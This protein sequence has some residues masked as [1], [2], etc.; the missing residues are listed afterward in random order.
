MAWKK[1][2]LDAVRRFDELAG[3]PGAQRKVM[4]GCPVYLLGG[5]RYALLHENRVV[6]RLSAEHAAKL[7]AKGGRP[8]EPMK[9]RPRKDRVV[10]PEAIAESPRSLRVWV[11]RAVEHAQE[12]GGR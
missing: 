8:F 10:V 1:N 7:M 9:G 5:Q 3:V 12:G 4:F 2:S 6:L 11:Q